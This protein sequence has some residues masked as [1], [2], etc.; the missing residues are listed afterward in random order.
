MM[1]YI[2]LLFCLFSF[3]HVLDEQI[4]QHRDQISQSGLY[5]LSP[6]LAQASPLMFQQASTPGHY[7]TEE[8][9]MGVVSTMSEKNVI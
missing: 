8:P 7:K 2:L 4:T 9:G 5:L 6:W 3:C 1:I